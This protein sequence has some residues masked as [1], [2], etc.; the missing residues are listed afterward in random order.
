MTSSQ[1][2]S[3]YYRDGCHLCE[4][5]AASLFR[6]WPAVAE[7]MRWVDVNSAP[8]LEREYGMDVPVLAAGQ[9]VICRRF[10]DH[11]CLT[12]YFGTPANPV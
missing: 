12:E 6:H 3:F 11:Q 10:P 1:I 2:L 5:M 9:Q 4:E 8:E 7:N